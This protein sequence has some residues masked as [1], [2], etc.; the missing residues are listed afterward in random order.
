M[1]ND[2]A[3]RVAERVVDRLW[4]HKRSG[5]YLKDV[6]KIEVL[7][8]FDILPPGF[9]YKPV[10][11]CVSAFEVD[12]PKRFTVTRSA[13]VEVN[14]AVIGQHYGK[15]LEGYRMFTSVI[16]ELATICIMEEM[17][18]LWGNRDSTVSYT[19]T[20]AIAALS[21]P[22]MPKASYGGVELSNNVDAMF[23]RVMWNML[24]DEPWDGTWNL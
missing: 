19:G 1:T 23:A 10:M 15:A 14:V 8:I 18:K 20:K 9:S 22:T 16:G 3:S 12:W 7:P 13:D 11:L 21:T 4:R 2:V 24:I 5:K 17:Q 6:V